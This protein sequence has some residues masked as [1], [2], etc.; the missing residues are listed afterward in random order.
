MSALDHDCDVG[1]LFVDGCKFFGNTAI[2]SKYY[3]DQLQV[4]DRDIHCVRRHHK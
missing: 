3:T 2:G 1:P 4:R